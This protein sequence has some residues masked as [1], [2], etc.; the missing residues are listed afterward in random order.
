MVKVNHFLLSL[1]ELSVWA[2][3]VLHE[4]NPVESI[5]WFDDI[6]NAMELHNSQQLDKIKKV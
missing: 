1:F 4:V 5:D 2:K 6:Q 3:T